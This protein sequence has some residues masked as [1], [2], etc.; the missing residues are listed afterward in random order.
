M[1]EWVGKTLGKVRLEL[2]LARGGMAEVYLGMH[3]T[4]RRPVAVKLLRTQFLDDPDLLNRF[5]REARVVAML[6][7]PNIVQVFDFDTFQNQPYLV[8]EYVSGVTLSTCLRDL[9][10]KGERLDLM[11]VGGLLDRLAEALEYAHE[12]GV[13]HRDVKP[14]NII[15]T[16]RLHPVEKNK[17]LPF[18]VQPVLTDFGL[19]RLLHGG[20]Q[21][22]TGQIAGTPA[23]MSPEQARGDRTDARTDIYSLGI[24]LY[25]MLAGRTPFE[26]D[27]S[28]GMMMKHINEP[29]SPIPGLAP[30]LQE[31]ID[32]VLAKQPEDRFQTPR[33]LSRAFAAALRARAEAFTRPPSRRPRLMKRGHARRPAS[34]SQIV[35]PLL[36]AAAIVALLVSIFVLAGRPLPVTG[37]APTQQAVEPSAQAAT[38]A[39]DGGSHS[40]QEMLALLRVQDGSDLADKATLTAFALPQPAKGTRYE[41]WLLGDG[42]ESRRSLGTLKLDAGGK[43]TLSFLNSSGANLI[44]HY[45]TLEITLEPETDANPN[46]NGPIV[47]R[48]GIPAD[49]LLHVRH[50]LVSFHST[51]GGIGLV[52][53]L[54]LD[55]ELLDVLAN[56]MLAKYQTGS[57]D[58]VR[59]NAEMMLNLLVGSQSEDYQDW[60]QNGN[61]QDP[62]DGF[63][64]LLNGDQVG[65]IEGTF[66]HAAYAATSNN[67]TQNMILH[68]VH[69]QVCAQNIEGWAPQ[70]RSLLKQML[71][72]EI[73]PAS[74]PLVRQVVVLADEMLVGIDL[75]GNEQIEAV[76]GECGART[77]YQHAYYMFDIP[78]Y[79]SER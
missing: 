31:V 37:D 64:M 28:L 75:N 12:S 72:A 23:Y 3:T 30:E 20:A 56:E 4:L 6:R 40:G 49:G 70:L 17:P 14:G 43:G 33:E 8:M 19:V 47:Y 11:T 38:G 41:A 57:H 74:E 34:I 79:A 9:H 66:S 42:G 61:L 25:E 35:R 78:I 77:A 67:A 44:E 24:V 65:Y 62:G 2:L 45:D 69:V 15:L 59:K 46:P 29:P 5:Q 68:G 51:P 53:G 63:G 54:R 32:R 10:Q 1:T 50:L 7:H 36:G 48:A 76:A 39:S 60:D 27:S 55:A 71:G 18:D 21:T 58:R 13:I 52:Q 73:G 26:A 16:S 22:A